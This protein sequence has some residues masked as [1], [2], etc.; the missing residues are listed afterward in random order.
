MDKKIA[1]IDIGS[2]S[3]RYACFGG[4]PFVQ[5]ELSSTV[6]ADGL[7]QS[8]LLKEDAIERTAAAV[9][10]F[11]DK[12]RAA[13]VQE[14]YAFATEAIRAAK[15][16][17]EAA[18]AIE[19]RA[20]VP[21][22]V[23]SGETEAKIGFMGASPSPLAPCALFDIGGASAELI[24]GQ[25]E[26]ISYRK[27]LP[28]GCVRL[29]DGSGGS[30]EKAARILES[31]IP[32][33]GAL[34]AFTTLTGIGGTATSLGGMLA[35]PQKYDPKK[36][37]GTSVPREFLCEVCARFFAGEPLRKAFPCLTENRAALI[38]YGAMIAAAILDH[39]QATSFTVSEHDNMEGYLLYKNTKKS[40]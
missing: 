18:L 24:C 33:Y 34:P 5:K 15:N 16:G 10:S 13:G 17:K 39:V 22:D 1:I 36:V 32:F 26:Q 6:L 29:R 12:A 35:C 28:V 20:K 11:C 7:F 40:V 30:E 8:G 9:A 19:T 14:I 38:G 31:T 3:V 23:V 21:V 2:N 25:G 4:E 27:S 37:H